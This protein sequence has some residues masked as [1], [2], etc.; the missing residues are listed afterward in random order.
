MQNTP[1][2]QHC[3][4]EF[5]LTYALYREKKLNYAD[6]EIV[7]NR[8]NKPSLRDYPNIHYNISHC[9]GL[10]ACVLSD[11]PVGIDVEKIR[12][13]SISA[14]KRVC[15]KLE[16][17]DIQRSKDK[18]RHFFIYWTL[19]ESCVKA[20]GYGITYPM[21]KVVFRLTD[22]EIRCITQPEYHFKLIEDSSSFVIAVCYKRYENY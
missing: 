12:P 13:F 3:F 9:K 21:K 15:E 5:L 14:A 16:M 19:K 1:A 4:G 10:T 20:I 2:A 11:V 6:Q 22:N 8:W 18:D 7:Y 17:E